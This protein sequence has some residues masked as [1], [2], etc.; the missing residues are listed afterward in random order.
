[1]AVAA[2]GLPRLQLFDS[3]GRPL[4]GGLLDSYAA[5]TTTPLATYADALGV[6]PNANP[7]V[8]DSGGFCDV[9]LTT[10]VAYKFRARTSAGVTLW[11]VDN[12]T[13]AATSTAAQ[14][15]PTGCSITATG[16]STFTGS[17]GDSKLVISGALQANKII[18][19]VSVTVLQQFGTSQ[20]AASL[21][22]GD[23]GLIDRW[24]SG[25]SLL[26]GT[27]PLR[28]GGMPLYSVATDLW[29]SIEQ[30]LFDGTGS[31]QAMVYSIGLT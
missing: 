10:A 3:S 9:W 24:G 11:T 18:L 22:F 15:L 14:L 2:L 25:L 26:V 28:Q 31:A 1:M 19:G 7:I 23:P 6:T 21:A 30:G 20:G 13:L 4:A 12:I 17:A 29:L 5:G 27:K 8:C 16:P